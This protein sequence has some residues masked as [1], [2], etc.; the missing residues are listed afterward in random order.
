MQEIIL[1]VNSK[2]LLVAFPEIEVE[3]KQLF[4]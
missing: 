3:I 2:L 4:P 1:D